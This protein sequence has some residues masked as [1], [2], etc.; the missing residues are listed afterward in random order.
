MVMPM[1]DISGQTFGRSYAIGPIM[2][3]GAGRSMLWHCVCDCGDHF[4]AVGSDL[5]RGQSQSCGCL[6]KERLSRRN[7]RKGADSPSWKG[8]RHD[9]GSGY[10]RVWTSSGYAM[11]HRVVM[12]EHLGRPLLDGESVHHVN[13]I[14]DDNRIKNL[15]L[16][17]STHP[18]GQRVSDKVAWCGRFLRTYAPELLAREN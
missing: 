4:V 3:R 1:K 18:S 12:A 16:W 17:V 11:E 7:K 13:G 2:G 5:R 6:W 14:K 9:D 15:E 8:G 10:T